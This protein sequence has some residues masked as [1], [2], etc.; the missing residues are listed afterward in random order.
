MSGHS[1]W[2]T[3][4]RKKGVTDSRRGAVFTRLAKNI[5]ISARE[6]G[7]DLTAN[8]KLRLMVDKARAANMPKDN[9][10]RAIKRG[11]GEEKGAAAYEEITYEGFAQHGVALILEIVTDNRNR[12]VAELRHLLN[13]VG[14]N[15][16]EAGSVAWQFERR[17]YL[18]FNPGGRAEEALFEMLVDAGAD[19]V[20]YTPEFVEV[21]GAV[22]RFK[23][24]TEALAAA[25]IAPDEA[26][27]RMEP[28]NPLSLTPSETA[29]VMRTVEHLEDLDDV[30]E[31]YTNLQITDEAMAALEVA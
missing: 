1:K 11:T 22:E 4:K 25:G 29:Q 18:A 2:S 3:I 10:D 19:D 24:L 17:A 30:Q 12:A 23:A 6:G 15:L 26:Q 7:G 16:G 9:I 27:V 8:F 21:Y 5:S 28:T 14:G 31:V 13:K 20:Q